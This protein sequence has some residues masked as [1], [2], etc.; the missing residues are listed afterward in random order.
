[1]KQ[2]KQIVKLISLLLLSA[3][4][5]KAGAAQPQKVDIN[6]QIVT[7]CSVERVDVAGCQTRPTT[8]INSDHILSAILAPSPRG[9][10]YL[11]FESWV[12]GFARYASYYKNT[13]QIYITTNENS[14]VSH[15][16]KISHIGVG[17][18]SAHNQTVSVY[19]Q[20]TITSPLHFYAQL[21]IPTNAR[22]FLALKKQISPYRVYFIFPE[23]VS[24]EAFDIFYK[25]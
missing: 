25:E 11:R 5:T 19:I 2:T 1:M 23:I 24:S 4:L 13:G 12:G 21:E 20:E 16:K 10:N 18:L 15:P 17:N 22:E 7:T 8:I 3:N 14:Q 9:L 6:V